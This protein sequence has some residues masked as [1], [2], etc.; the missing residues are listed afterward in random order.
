MSSNVT[1]L[2]DVADWYD[3][4]TN[5][6]IEWRAG[7]F[8]RVDPNGRSGWNRWWQPLGFW[9]AWGDGLVRMTQG[10]VDTLRVGN[11]VRQ[12]GWS[13]YGHDALRVLNIFD[14]A[15]RIIGR[16]G[17][18]LRVALQP[19][20]TVT[21][22]WYSFLNALDRT[23]HYFFISV[24][25]LMN[26]VGIS[27]AAIIS[28][29]GTTPQMFR[30]LVDHLAT[31]RI[32]MEE[33]TVPLES[34]GWEALMRFAQIRRRGVFVIGF[35][36]ATQAA[37]AVRSTASEGHALLVTYSRQHGLIFQDT[38]GQ[39]YAGL[40]ALRQAYPDATIARSFPLIFIRDSAMVTSSALASG[41]A[42]TT[43]A[44][45]QASGE[46]SSILEN[47]VVPVMA[48]VSEAVGRD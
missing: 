32:Q 29:R 38:T 16:V 14:G 39:I 21:C 37:N 3:R 2:G 36:Y 13:G 4:Q 41:A 33:L 30:R 22:V 6:L 5:G 35:H 31:L 1:F 45:A 12:G 26:A 40:G 20:G 25:D 15:G 34:G 43:R 19:A 27:E 10:V 47:I 28:A 17:R 48:I 46:G 24:R 42:Q 18:V 44:A 11:G 23:G 9:M 8:R 7:I